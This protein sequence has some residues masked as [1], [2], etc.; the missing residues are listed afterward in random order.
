MTISVR[1]DKSLQ[2]KLTRLADEKGLSRSALVREFLLAYLA[3]EES[4]KTPWELGK[5]LFRFMR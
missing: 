3:R 2:R 5:D 1:L 4:W